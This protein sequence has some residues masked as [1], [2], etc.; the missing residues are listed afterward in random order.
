MTRTRIVQ[1]LAAGLAAWFAT[2]AWTPLYADPWA[3]MLPACSFVLLSLAGLGLRSRLRAPVVIFLE[4][5]LALAVLEAHQIATD[6]RHWSA[7]RHV[8]STLTDGARHLDEYSSPAPT[9][10]HDVAVLL[11]ACGLL[12]WLCVETLACTLH[13]ASLTGFPLLLALTVPITVLDGRLPLWVLLGCLVTYLGMIACEHSLQ[14]RGWGRSLSPDVSHA[15]VGIVPIT[16]LAVVALSCGLLLSTVLPLGRG[17]SHDDGGRNV[18]GNLTLGSPILNL[19]RDLIQRSHTPMVTVS[20]NDPD[21]SYLT[22]TVLDQFTGTQWQASLRDLPPTNSVN[23]IF[24]T[25]AGIA[26][27]VQATNTWRFALAPALRTRW[28][29]IPTPTA[30]LRVAEGD[31]RYDATTLDVADV[32]PSGSSGGLHYTAKS[33]DPTY[34]PATLN[35]AGPPVGT[36]IDH[37][38]SLPRQVPVALTRTARQVTRGAHTEFNQLVALQRWFR[39]TGGFRYSTAPAPGSGMALLAR[40]VTTDRVGYCEQFAAAMAVMARTLGIPS[41]VVVGFLRPTGKSPATGSVEFTSDDLH[42]WPEFYFSGSGWVRFD[43]TPAVRSGAGPAYARQEVRPP[44]SQASQG[45]ST[46]PTPV[47]TPTPTPKQATGTTSSASDTGG[48]TL[49]W[50]VFPVLALLLCVAPRIVRARQRRRRLAPLTAPEFAAGCWDELRATAIDLDLTWPAHGTIRSILAGL[51][52][53]VS[54]DPHAVAE[55]DWLAG[56]LERT[57]YA[58]DAQISDTERSRA[59]DVVAL[60][61]HEMTMATASRAVRRATWLPRSLTDRTR[62]VD[63]SRRGD[64]RPS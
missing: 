62:V 6:P 48:S 47:A 37:M 27:N 34:S 16:G 56:V 52:S 51:R 31:W 9:H 61:R 49:W 42:A 5:L 60:W 22:L 33:F 29:P 30:Q 39:E 28:L 32:S 10:F 40:F 57:W 12:V 13:R 50:L 19:R 2:G 26:P 20:T 53:R 59:L 23:G 41:R 64:Q 55:L 44:R 24:P 45:P 18:G 4:T 17:I 63:R 11:L 7:A 15:A 8:W 3:F 25:P 43:P 46:A 14:T 38:T 21:P 36:V 35:E 58:A 1:S 54:T